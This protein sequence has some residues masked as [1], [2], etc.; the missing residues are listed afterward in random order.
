MTL[1]PFLKPWIDLNIVIQ[2]KVSQKT[3]KKTLVRSKS[4][5]GWC[6]IMKKN[7]PKGSFSVM[8]VPR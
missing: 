8:L 4:G 7:P 1:V 5:S 2:S 6:K 3:E